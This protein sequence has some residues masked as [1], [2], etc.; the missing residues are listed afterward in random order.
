[1]TE[2]ENLENLNI[3]DLEIKDLIPQSF[4]GTVVSVVNGL[5]TLYLPIG[6]DGPKFKTF[7]KSRG[8]IFSKDVLE[9]NRGKECGKY[10]LIEGNGERKVVRIIEDEEMLL[11]QSLRLIKG[12]VKDK[13]YMLLRNLAQNEKLT[14]AGRY[15]DKEN[16]DYE[17][18]VEEMIVTPQVKAVEEDH[19]ATTTSIS[20]FDE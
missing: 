8:G 20:L 15:I 13:P 16:S 12:I 6:M 2:K 11:F 14:S 1:M 7:R 10:V 19:D 5:Q 18:E 3:K 4:N 9:Y 17:I